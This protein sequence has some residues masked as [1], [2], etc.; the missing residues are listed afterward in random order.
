MPNETQTRTSLPQFDRLYGKI[1]A[2][3][4]P[5][6]E[7]EKRG[8]GL[9]QTLF[10][11]GMYGLSFGIYHPKFSEE[12]RKLHPILFAKIPLREKVLDKIPGVGL[13]AE[14][15][16]PYDLSLAS[17]ITL[18]PLGAAIR[19]FSGAGR[20]LLKILRLDQPVLRTTTG[21][22]KKVIDKFRPKL[23]PA[24]RETQAA[25]WGRRIA[26]EVALGWGL[27]AGHSIKSFWEES[28]K[29]K[30]N[31]VRPLIEL[32]ISI[33][34]NSIAFPMLSAVFSG[35]MVGVARV[36]SKLHRKGTEPIVAE[37]EK[38]ITEPGVKVLNEVI[39]R[40]EQELIPNLMNLPEKEFLAKIMAPEIV[41]KIGLDKLSFFDIKRVTDIT[42][43]DIRLVVS[44]YLERGVFPAGMSAEA[45]E[46]IGRIADAIR[47]EA[48]RAIT[49]EVRTADDILSRLIKGKDWKRVTRLLPEETRRK[50]ITEWAPQ[51]KDLVLSVANNALKNRQI[52]ILDPVTLKFLA[53]NP[54]LIDRIRSAIGIAQANTLAKL[55]D[56]WTPEMKADFSKAV[57]PEAL[58][59][60]TQMKNEWFKTQ[61]Q[62]VAETSPELLP[63]FDAMEKE[64]SDIFEKEI[65]GKIF[66]E[67]FNIAAKQ[68]KVVLQTAD[69]GEGIIQFVKAMTNSPSPAIVTKTLNEGFR[70]ASRIETKEILRKYNELLEDPFTEL[71]KKITKGSLTTEQL[72]GAVTTKELSTQITKKLSEARERPID[73]VQ[74]R[75]LNNKAYNE[76]DLVADTRQLMGLSRS[77]FANAW[78]EFKSTGKMT[79]P[80]KQMINSAFQFYVGKFLPTAKI[81]HFTK[82][83]LARISLL[84]EELEKEALTFKILNEPGFIGARETAKETVAAVKMAE[85]TLQ[86]AIQRG[87][88]TRVF[89]KEI[90]E[91]VPPQ[92]LKMFAES[93]SKT[94]FM[95]EF[96]S[97]WGGGALLEPF[98]VGGKYGLAKVPK[99][100]DKFKLW[101]V[102]T[103]EGA[104]FKVI[105]EKKELTRTSYLLEA[106]E[107]KISAS[108]EEIGF[109]SLLANSRGRSVS[110]A[111]SN[112]LEQN[113]K[114]I[115]KAGEVVAAARKI[116]PAQLAAEREIVR[117]KMVD[118]IIKN[119][120][121][122]KAMGEIWT[123]GIMAEPG[124]RIRTAEEIWIAQPST[125]P[126]W[127]P[128]RLRRK[129]ILNEVLPY[130]SPETFDV[131]KTKRARE[132][133]W[134]ILEEIDKRAK[135]DNSD[136]R[137]A[138]K[139]LYER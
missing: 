116:S 13:V 28:K 73:Y 14:A 135:I 59:M 87:A 99:V 113:S 68:H 112:L 42:K 104:E 111:I 26:N 25:Y 22:S 32:G 77:D 11:L 110:E 74:E 97:R 121:M 137:E 39:D 56:M 34:L 27:A 122:Q 1:P 60:K 98:V 96:Y 16:L 64:M 125:F 85:D 9:L 23:E 38:K 82:D 127:I 36:W 93:T 115:P 101:S 20:A 136:L 84:K 70:A 47:T 131:P 75:I 134:I 41:Q 37:A 132:L 123:E 63:Q 61:R 44:D 52:E 107:G 118:V 30:P 18:L 19:G 71:Q 126:K 92:I 69:G 80:L 54:S 50:D 62:K 35:S 12:E 88:I 40:S 89:T 65:G 8:R 46:K 31:Y 109:F 90:T 10:G 103:P 138:L 86:D 102:I 72:P 120:P 94:E 43:A 57:F 45:K 51:E 49:M 130:L 105:A 79:L 81:K 6:T 33:P 114:L 124:R 95:S 4:V 3:P 29:E 100:G 15:F 128:E 58:R 66:S 91:K 48:Q 83:P 24:I 55:N 5:E 2:I 129:D 17:V 76:W 106:K 119:E 139:V 21:I 108:A 133:F 53:E 67:A 7:I 117:E 78:Y